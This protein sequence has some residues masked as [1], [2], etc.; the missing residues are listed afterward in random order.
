[1]TFKKRLEYNISNLLKR[2][3]QPLK[4]KKI[5]ISI[6]FD[7][8]ILYFLFISSIGYLYFVKGEKVEKSI[9]INQTGGDDIVIQ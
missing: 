6:S 7:N 1:M 3:I 2:S 5:G 9:T 8:Y 4:I